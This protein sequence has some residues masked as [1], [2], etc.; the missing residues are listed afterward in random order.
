MIDAVAEQKRRHMLD[1]LD[2]G[3]V[4]IH[5]DPRVEGVEI[6]DQ[7]RGDPV[8]RLNVA[9][10]F[11]LP[12]L[13]VDA[14][15]IYAVLSFNRLDFGCVMPWPAVFALTSPDDGHEGAVWPTAIPAELAGFFAD[16]QDTDDPM[17]VRIGPKGPT[18]AAAPSPAP[19][20]ATPLSPARV[21]PLTE[22]DVAPPPPPPPIFVVHDGGKA[23]D[24][25]EPEAETPD[26]SPPPRRRPPTLTVV[27]D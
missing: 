9:Y 21:R 14:D 15:G 24:A 18:L 12:A 19:L 10:G 5:L 20:A 13:T 16:V 4:M 23:D 7:F 3:L 2:R 8:L 1:M 17:A 25:V 6:P 27:K 11:N 26:D 22:D